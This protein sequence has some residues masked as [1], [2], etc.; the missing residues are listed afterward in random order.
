MKSTN[1]ASHSRG[2]ARE[3]CSLMVSYSH[4]QY[5]LKLPKKKFAGV[6]SGHIPSELNGTASFFLPGVLKMSFQIN[7]MS[8]TIIFR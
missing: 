1:F 6:A 7:K 3:F 5:S 2:L 8:D 4:Q